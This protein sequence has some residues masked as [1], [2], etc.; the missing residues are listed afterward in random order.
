MPTQEPYLVLTH[1]QIQS[2]I[3]R[4]AFQIL[5]DTFGE[6]EIVLVGIVSNGYELAKRL[7]GVIEKMSTMRVELLQV[8][9]DKTGRVLNGTSDRPIEVCNHKTIVL[10]DD[11][12]NSGKTMAYCFGMFLNNPVR[13]I[14]SVV[15]V[16]RS[17]RLFPLTVDFF[18]IELA[19]IIKEHIRVVFNGDNDGVYL[20]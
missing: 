3:R 14:R 18:G 12:L 19:T 6:Q 4:I 5:E 20:S 15:L 11:V 16:K 1:Q 10:V 8:T 17:H 2:K 13:K 9:I 7:T